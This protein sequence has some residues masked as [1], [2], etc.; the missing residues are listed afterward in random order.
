MPNTQHLNSE[1]LEA[2]LPHIRQSPRTE[3]ELQLI[4]RR[5]K[6]LE[7]ELLSEAK[8]D[9]HEGLIGDNW[10]FK[11]SSRTPDKSPHPD[12]QLTII[13]ARAIDLV[14]QTK[15]RWSLAGDQLYIDLDL[16]EK[17]LPAETRISLG[18][19]VVEIT[20]QPH[21]GCQKFVD[22]Y[23]LAAMKFVNSM[24]GRELNLRGVNAKV[25]EPGVIKIGD[26]AIVMRP[27]D[28]D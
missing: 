23:G 16:S 5:P 28:N 26:K 21:T 17:N 2:G 27:E 4:V 13:N 7:R 8:L 9:R 22:R 15:E 6:V 25:I 20:A 1:Q 19:A 18:T 12:M 10:Q 14:A 24:V 11:P 3:G